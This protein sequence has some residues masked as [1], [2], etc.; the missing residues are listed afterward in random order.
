VD[1]N[2]GS[3]RGYRRCHTRRLGAHRPEWA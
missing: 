3:G 1:L 2:R